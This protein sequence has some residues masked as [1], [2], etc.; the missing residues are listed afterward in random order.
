[1]P[2]Y[3]DKMSVRQMVDLAAFLQS[4]YIAAIR[5]GRLVSGFRYQYLIL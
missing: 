4:R 1:M 3:T 2:N 5:V